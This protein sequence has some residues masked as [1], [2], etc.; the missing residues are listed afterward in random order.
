MCGITALSRASHSSIP[1]GYRAVLAALL[2][3][4]HRGP[5]STGVAWTRGKQGKVWYDKRVGPASEVAG[6]LS[7]DR[8]VPIRTA[9]GH[10][11]WSTQGAHT[12][13]NAHPVVADNICLV[14]NGVVSNDDD[15]I[16]VAGN[17][18]RVGEVDSWAIAA[19]IAAQHELGA[20]HPGELL[21][22]IKGDAAVAWI[23]ANDPKSLHLARVTGRPMTIAWTRRGDLLM[24]STRASL[25]RTAT[26]IGVGLTGVTD[27]PVGCYLRIVQGK[28]VERR[29]F[30]G[31]SDTAPAKPARLPL[32]WDD[33]PAIVQHRRSVRQRRMSVTDLFE[34]PMA[35]RDDA[36]WAEVDEVLGVDRARWS[37]AEQR[38][39][40]PKTGPFDPNTEGRS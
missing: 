14:H 34:T 9:I 16:A 13:D 36:F 30:N 22:L 31:T 27:V 39:L 23:D 19:L 2:S 5:D 8:K 10:T 3:I 18:P 21:E 11:R 29:R 38:W 6:D 15:L 4:E 17:P 32:D 1:D 33:E 40:D 28:I 35:E 37:T 26:L 7:L 24:S 20:E 25:R 12:Y